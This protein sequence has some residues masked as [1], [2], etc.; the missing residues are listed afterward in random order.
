[1]NLRVAALG[2]GEAGGRIAADLVAAGASVAGWDPDPS[3]AVDGVVPAADAVEAVRGAD[4]VLSANSAGAAVAAAQG[5]APGVSPGQVYADLNSA[6]PSVKV[7]VGEVVEPCG[8]LFVDVAL[9]GPVPNRGL[10]TPS[11]VSG[12]GAAEYAARLGPL[13]AVVE[14]VG[15]E[16][17]AAAERK[18]LRSVFMKG[19][20]AAIVESLRAAE[21]AGREEWLRAEIAAVLESADETLLE[22]LVT[23]SRVHAARRV[24]EMEA[25]C[26]L[27]RELEVEPRIA[28]A[29]AAVLAELASEGVR[30]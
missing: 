29:A 13:G 14:I 1:V 22:R 23:G 7:A 15:S 5:C 27:L 11:L 21:A 19:L 9:L 30:A 17:G 10:Q 2:L 6:A 24:Q 4:V 8:A 16:P 12:P 18:L 3:R 26:E 25:A 28:A 20:A